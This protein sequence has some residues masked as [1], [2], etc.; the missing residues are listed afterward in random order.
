MAGGGSGGHVIP[1][2]AVARELRARGT[3]GS[4]HRHAARHGSEAGACRKFRHRVDR[5]RR[6]QSRGP[7][8]NAFDAG[9]SAV[10]RLA[11][12]AHAGPGQTRGRFFHGRLCGGTGAARRAVETIAGGGD[13]AERGA[14]FHAPAAGAI[15]RA[16]VSQLSG[17]CALVPERPH[18]S[19]R[20][21]RARRVFR[22]LAQ[23]A[24]ADCYDPDHG[25][26]PGFADAQSRRRRE[27]A[28][29][30]G[31][32]DPIAASNRR[33]SVRGFGGAIPRSPV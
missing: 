13:G 2:L 7:A 32:V 31:L 14:R 19:D 9:R 26:Q 28:A 23:A 6:T 22:R 21:A 4:L 25:R 33:R 3:R 8:S 5:N 12:G 20:A 17:N 18:R 29:V 16:G 15:R 30:E 1:A 24:R 27:L 10:Q 11:G